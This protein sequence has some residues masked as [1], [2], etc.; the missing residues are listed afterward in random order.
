M[1]AMQH[2]HGERTVETDAGRRLIA[3]D[4]IF[5]AGILEGLAAQATEGSQRK[6]I[7]DRA[8]SLRVSAVDLVE[9]E[10]RNP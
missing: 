6:A 3:G 10:G 5:V 9:V 7:M 4:F 8:W 1:R 2:P